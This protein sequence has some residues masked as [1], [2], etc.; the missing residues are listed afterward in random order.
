LKAHHPVEFMAA[1]LST[2]I[3]NTEKIVSNVAECRRAGIPVLPPDVNTSD[4]EFTVDRLDDQRTAVRFGLAAVKNVGAAAVRAVIDARAGRPHQRFATLDDFCDTVDWGSVNRRA[5]E[6]FAKS[7]A[8]DCFGNRSFVLSRLDAAVASGQQRQKASA[9]GQTSL[10][11]A[12]QALA[13][14]PTSV[15]TTPIR[16][17]PQKELLT[18]EKE[19]LGLYLSA[20]P[21][22]EVL[23]PTARAGTTQIGELPN[24]TPGDKVRVIGMVNG[25]RRITTKKNR[26]MAIVDFEDLTGNVELVVFPDCFDVVAADLLPDTILEVLAKLERRG[27][28][29]QLVCETASTQVAPAVNQTPPR[30]LH[31]RLPTTP[32]VW[33]DIRLM[34]TLDA[35]LRRHEGD[36]NVVIHLPH[37]ASSVTLR[38]RTLRVDWSS[39]LAG[40]LHEVVGAER[41]ELEEPRIAS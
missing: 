20:H 37:G 16:E 18:W 13:V 34:Q 24:R 1:M 7:G 8:L 38:S 27:E 22:S 9:R 25:V 12:N 5:V 26:T 4:F 39:D 2:E 30:S 3:G 17:I 32:D 28:Q 14:A 29:L 31:L 23:G 10:F 33:Q 40:E 41:I 6:C 21:L 36:D 15:V 19:L 11:G 35:I